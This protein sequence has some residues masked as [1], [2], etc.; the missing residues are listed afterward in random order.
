MKKV[1]II[2][3]ICSLFY[4]NIFSQNNFK[5]EGSEGFV[6][7][8]YFGGNEPKGYEKVFAGYGLQTEFD[9]WKNVYNLNS[10]NFKLG[11]G[12]TRFSYL[13]EYGYTF[14]AVDA[15]FSSYINFKI[16]MD[17]KPTWSKITFLLNSTN[18]FLFQKENQPLSQNRW[19]NNLDLGIRIKILKNV[20]L[21]FWSP[22]TLYSMANGISVFRPGNLLKY[23][24]KPFI[25]ITGLNLGI[26]YGFGKQ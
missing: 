7:F 6:F 11:I 14:F 26:S 4:N 2:L 20:K 17:Y 25:E 10:L 9:I 12:Y 23:N 5:I 24:L 18:Y 1:Y 19:F 15:E 22:I 13:Y 16:G 21:S 8:D 3:L